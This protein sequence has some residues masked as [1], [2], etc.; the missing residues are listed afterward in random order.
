MKPEKL[1]EL[2][3]REDFESELLC[4]IFGEE[5][6]YTL[7]TDDDGIEYQIIVEVKRGKKIK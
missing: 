2:F 7:F 3:V 6:V 5:Q 1:K 4:N